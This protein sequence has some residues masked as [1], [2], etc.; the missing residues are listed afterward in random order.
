MERAFGQ[1]TRCSIAPT[2]EA[3]SGR[4]ASYRSVTAAAQPRTEDSPR[5]DRHKA[6]SAYQQEVDRR[7]WIIRVRVEPVFGSEHNEQGGKLV[8]A[9]G[10]ARASAKIAA[11]E[12][13]LQ[14]APS[15]LCD[16]VGR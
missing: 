2:P 7:R 4:T 12:S 15:E 13:R 16:Q 9:I 1:G 5:G 14:P 8:R 3:R 10:W 11:R 6:L